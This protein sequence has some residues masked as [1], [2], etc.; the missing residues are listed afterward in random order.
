M[1]TQITTDS[2]SIS[3]DALG[4]S[5]SD[6]RGS[7]SLINELGAIRYRDAY[8]LKQEHGEAWFFDYGV[9]VSWNM[10][11]NARQKLIFTLRDYISDSFERPTSEQYSY[12]FSQSG[13]FNVHHDSIGLPDDSPLT[14][15]ALSHGFA[16]SA[17]LD[18]FEEKAQK[19]IQDNAFISKELAKKGKVSIGRRELA[20]LRGVLFD[21]SSDIALHF[22]LLDT[23]EFFW[24]YPELEPYYL[25]ITN[26]LDLNARLNIL[27]KKLETIH[28]LLDMIS[29]EQN[30]KHS[31][32]LEW[33]IIWLIAVDII[34]YFF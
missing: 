15:L 18:F 11:E 3:I 30:H 10:P 28:G 32:F 29:S 14:R 1:T 13:Q 12:F 21:T 5:L 8:L 6:E 25:R 19:V 16:Q 9:L 26:Y 24:D 27:N 33:I 4:T 34:I 20:K 22:N 23:P 2:F 31:A 17:K 7:E